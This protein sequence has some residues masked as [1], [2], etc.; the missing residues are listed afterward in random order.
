MKLR[1]ALVSITLATTTL[2]LAESPAE[3]NFPLPTPIPTVCVGEETGPLPEVNVVDGTEEVVEQLS[4][5]EK[6]QAKI[7]AKIEK[8]QAKLEAYNDCILVSDSMTELKSCKK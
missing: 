6:K 4:K 5:F 8:K 1:N 7:L 3:V 2:I